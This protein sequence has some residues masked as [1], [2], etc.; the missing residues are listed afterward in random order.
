[1][2]LSDDIL[3][4]LKVPSLVSV[5]GRIELDRQSRVDTIRES[6][7]FTIPMRF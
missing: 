4:V 6:V 2:Q 3:T 1:M 5:E 7:V